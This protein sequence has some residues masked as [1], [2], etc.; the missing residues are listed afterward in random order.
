MSPCFFLGGGGADIKFTD[1]LDDIPK[2]CQKSFLRILD[3]SCV[4]VPVVTP[5]GSGPQYSARLSSSSSSSEDDLP[6]P[7]AKGGAAAAAV[8]PAA[9]AKSPSEDKD[10]FGAKF[11]RASFQEILQA[12]LLREKLVSNKTEKVRRGY[13]CFFSSR[14]ESRVL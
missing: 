6:P 3:V 5:V 1:F 10:I 12:E 9:S 8:P 13:N 7:P 11:S 2:G 14:L 4:K